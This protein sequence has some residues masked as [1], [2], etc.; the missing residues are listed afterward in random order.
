MSVSRRTFIH[1][2]IAAGTLFP[3]FS[4][5]FKKDSYSLNDLKRDE[6]Y[7]KKVADMYHQNVKF[8]N[9][10]SGYFS[11]SP[12]SV[13]N[14]WVNFVNE[15]NE[16]PSY[17]MRTRQN[18]MREKVRKTLAD[19][20]GVQTDELIL[21]RNTTESMNIIIQGIKLEKGDEILRTNLEYPNIIQALDMRE[22]RFGT[23]VR[24]VDVP[25]HPK[26]QQEIV[27]MVI[28]AVNKKTKVILISHMV[29]LNGQVFPVKEVCAK[30]REM[31]LETIVDGAH[32]FSH[33]DM[34]VSEIGCDYYGSSLHKWLG[35][36]LGNGLLYV[37]K[38]N[39]E[40][41]WP[42]Y[43]DTAYDDDNIMK[44]EHL[45]TRPCSD[46]N[47]IIPAV[48]F[49][50]EIGKK[51]KSERLKFLQ[52]HWASELKDNKNIILNTPLGEGQSYGIANVGVK[53]LRPSE[54]ADKLFD[55]H[56]IFTVPIDDERGIRGVRV[57][58]NLY[59]TVEDIDKFI[60]AML[61]IAA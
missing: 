39:S 27:D 33:V 12:E 49:N 28:G 54:L 16:S 46:Q 4:M 2:S 34:D 3:L 10:E 36:P 55:D 13:K 26:S 53:N 50:L 48:D 21:T 41:L 6:N 5:D 42:L 59:S 15:I 45:G 17:Y 19:Y 1:N 20:A 23:K 25:I 24:I 37:K 40:R 35:A 31:G 9:L 11:P 32:S 51:E 58:P 22:R 56:N 38:G 7:W 29:F 52:M 60:E 57:S 30:A 14:Y 61:T 47:G 8:I 43:G 44:L 18:E